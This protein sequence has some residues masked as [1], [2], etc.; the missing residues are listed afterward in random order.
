MAKTGLT[1]PQRV[2][3]PRGRK[4]TGDIPS[5]PGQRVAVSS[6]SGAKQ[7]ITVP[8]M[9]VGEG[10]VA[11]GR[12]I[13]DAGLDYFQQTSLDFARDEEIQL[14]VASTDL[15]T[16]LDDIIARTD[17]TSEFP[18]SFKANEEMGTYVTNS[19]A[20]QEN[21]GH[22]DQFNE[23]FAQAAQLSLRTKSAAIAKTTREK[24]IDIISKQ[25]EEKYNAGFTRN[26]NSVTL[27]IQENQ[28]I[29]ED[30]SMILP[31]KTN[32][33]LKQ[34][35][36]ADLI[37]Y[38]TRQFMIKGNFDRARDSLY[39]DIAK[40]N[41]S[42]SSVLKAKYLRE[43]GNEI[44]KAEMDYAVAARVAAKGKNRFL[45]T[46]SGE[47]F[48]TET[49]EIVKATE[50]LTKDIIKTDH[51]LFK[52]TPGESQTVESV[53][54]ADRQQMTSIDT[55]TSPATLKLI[56]GT[57]APKNLKE[58]EIRANMIKNLPDYDEATK[59]GYTKEEKEAFTTRMALGNLISEQQNTKS[60]IENLPDYNEETKTGFTA[61]EKKRMIQSVLAPKMPKTAEESGQFK[62]IE[63]VE[64]QKI[65]STIPREVSSSVANTMARYYAMSFGRQT[66][67]GG[68][69][70]PPGY[71]KG[72]NAVMELA[73]KYWKTGKDGG[74]PM[75]YAEAMATAI[76]DV[77]AKNPELLPEKMH[78]EQQF[79][80]IVAPVLKP[81]ADKVSRVEATQEEL[82]AEFETTASA[83]DASMKTMED[84]L[85][86]ERF[87]A[88]ALE[89]GLSL[90]D[91]TG[92]WSGI[93]D[94]LGATLA[95]FP[96]LGQFANR[97]VTKAR[98]A[99]AMIARDFVRFVSLS[100]R[101]AVKEQQLIQGMFPGP[102]VFNSPRQAMFRLQ[103]FEQTLRKKL[104][105]MEKNL[106]FI[107]TPKQ[108]AEVREK[109]ELWTDMIQKIDRFSV[110]F[111][112][113]KTPAEAKQLTPE[114]VNEFWTAMNPEEKVDFV[115]NQPA[116]MAIIAL[117]MK[118]YQERQ[119]HRSKNV[120][121]V[122]GKD[123]PIE[124]TRN[125]KVK[126]N[127]K[128]KKK[129]KKKTIKQK[130]DELD[131]LKIKPQ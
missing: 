71:E 70:I 118:E 9:P 13:R 96:W 51:G 59:K 92:M 61:D 16:G 125:K 122:D 7:N 113:V 54:E 26:R 27:G 97:K 115:T 131:K 100:P 89:E 119:I 49:R 102:E 104:L 31:D 19:I 64:K 8:N 21:Q 110:D 36:D 94:A 67:D 65:V 40:T 5:S 48:D 116:S 42:P 105:K 81:P 22:S 6:G 24:Q 108:E 58:I 66:P 57:E 15:E 56:P 47:V 29:H 117:K 129:T 95:Q 75:D 32:L 46:K 127:T 37:L 126:N 28:K 124:D 91:A 84:E 53:A 18:A 2:D 79:K 35:A 111:A 128:I 63:E 106:P 12:S 99:Y 55:P 114:Q 3:P 1:L 76:E 50:S 11:F 34:K 68:Y 44:N 72:T 41:L 33:D 107:V 90:E 86:L 30:Y 62:G 77:R 88:A 25:A 130:L 121:R 23:R 69:N 43:I 52:I 17:F 120:M 83:N 80:N 87:K 123:V 78:F 112:L 4:K 82:E 14:R 73:T 98:L 45:M 85:A 93:Q 74:S 103:E 60:V 39:E 10:T 38:R 20:E 101:F 109:A